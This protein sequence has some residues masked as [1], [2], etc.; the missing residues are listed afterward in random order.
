MT[1]NGTGEQEPGN[2]THPDEVLEK[3]GD[4]W[5]M[6]PTYAS[7]ASFLRSSDAGTHTRMKL[8]HDV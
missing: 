3:Y 8:C 1:V 5:G 7:L 2:P 4:I 6:P